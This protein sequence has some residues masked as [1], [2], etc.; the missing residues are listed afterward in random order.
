M[1]PAVG[2]ELILW[3][4]GCASDET[5]IDV[6]PFVLCFT[7]SAPFEFGQDPQ[8][9]IFMSKERKD[10]HRYS[11]SLTRRETK[12]HGRQCSSPDSVLICCA[13]LCSGC[14]TTVKTVAVGQVKTILSRVTVNVPP[15]DGENI[16]SFVWA[17]SFHHAGLIVSL[18]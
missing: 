15:I 17:L 13:T 7:K 11:S 6:V 16:A 2:V 10:G 1:D 9:P 12:I 5:Q 4:R 14:V 8:E 3:Y 18:P